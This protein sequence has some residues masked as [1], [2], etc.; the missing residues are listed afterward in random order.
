MLIHGCQP[1]RFFERVLFLA[2][3]ALDFTASE[4]Q[5][6]QQQDEIRDFI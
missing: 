5:Q 6:C 4:F 2:T 1:P 3:V